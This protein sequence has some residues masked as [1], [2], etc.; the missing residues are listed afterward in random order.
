MF[1]LLSS[2]YTSVFLQSLLFF[3]CS[4]IGPSTREVRSLSSATSSTWPVLEYR[5][6][7]LMLFVFSFILCSRCIC[8]FCFRLFLL[9][10][11]LGKFFYC[12]LLFILFHIFSFEYISDAIH[13]LGLGASSRSSLVS[14]TDTTFVFVFSNA[15][16]FFIFGAFS[17]TFFL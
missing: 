5:C 9:F 1:L 17:E 2:A 13:E 10:F 15:A 7:F 8:W 11:I 14:S 16:F 4:A 12:Y 3:D 6:S